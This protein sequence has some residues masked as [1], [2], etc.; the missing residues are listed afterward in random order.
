MKKLIL[1][2]VL[3]VLLIPMAVRVPI[4][5]AGIRN[6]YD[7]NLKVLNPA[8]SGYKHFRLRNFKGHIVIL[9]F[10]AT[11]S[12]LCKNE[13]SI[14]EKFYKSE[15]ANG[16]IVVEA[17]V[18]N[19]LRGVRSFLKRYN[20][21][22]PVVY[23]TSRV[24]NN[25]GGVNDIPETFFISQN[26]YVISHWLGE[27]TMKI[28][29]GFLAKYPLLVTKARAKLAS[30]RYKA[31]N[32]M[33]N[34]CSRHNGCK[35][36][37]SSEYVNGSYAIYKSGSFVL[38][39]SMNNVNDFVI[40]KS[41]FSTQLQHKLVFMSKQNGFSNAST[42]NLTTAFVSYIT[43]PITKQNKD[44]YYLIRALGRKKVFNRSILNTIQGL[45]NMVATGNLKDFNE[46]VNLFVRHLIK[47]N[48]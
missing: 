23:A 48:K 3:A 36:R 12:P 8:L 47:I 27:A 43:Q 25:Y 16:V 34:Y 35:V 14:L 31:I 1:S 32:I 29:K 40:T 38:T 6:K 9:N 18:N 15:K 37:Y 24:I 4:A 17:N 5:S 26:G 11:W 13:M 33:N 28:Y 44:Q 30:N 19:N 20:I 42:M 41:L 22:Y 45:T 39:D 2:L 21:T 7:F 10:C 46:L